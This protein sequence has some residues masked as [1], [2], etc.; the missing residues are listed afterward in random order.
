MTGPAVIDGIVADND[1]VRSSVLP[2][3]LPFPADHML[4]EKLQR[5]L[6]LYFEFFPKRHAETRLGL[7]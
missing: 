1:V 4:I 6:E 7:P 2:V 5:I 3:Y